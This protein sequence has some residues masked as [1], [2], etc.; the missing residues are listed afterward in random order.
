MKQASSRWIALGVLTCGLATVSW[1]DLNQVVTL[2][3][4]SALNM[5]TGATSSSGGD[6]LWTG[7]AITP[8]GNATAAS[9]GDVPYNILT[10]AVITNLPGFSKAEISGRDLAVNQV[11]VVHTNANRYAKALVQSNSG[12]VIRLQFTTYGAPAGTSGGPVITAIQNNSSR[13]RVGLPNYGIAPSS[14]FVVTGNALSDA[15]Q[16][17]LQSSQPP[18]LPI[19]LNGTSITVVVNGVTTRPPLYYTSPGQ[20]AAVMPANTPVGSGTLTVTHNGL[21]SAPAT[22]QVVPAALGI[23]TYDVNT[24][25]ATD[26]ATGALLTYTNSGSP[27]QTI[28]LWTTGLGANPA[29]SD[30]TFTTTP[31]S[32][33]TS[34]QIFIGG[35]PAT[36]LYQGA[37]G[38]PAVNQINLTIPQAVSTGC[39]VPL[40]AI[41]GNV[42]SNVVTL[43]IAT[44]GGAC[45]D[46]VSGLNGSQISPAGGT[47]T[48]R[49]GLVSLIQTTTPNLRAGPTVSQSATAAFIRYTG[50]SYTPQNSVSP[51][52]CILPNAVPV[53][54]LTGLDPGSISLTGPSGVSTTLGTPGGIRGTFFSNLPANTLSSG[55]TFTFRGTGGADVGA[56]T[57]TITLANPL[58]NWTNQSAAAS[59]DR[60]QGLR[61]T[62]TG[63]NPGSFVSISGAAIAGGLPVG[64][65][66]LAPAE[67]GQFTVPSYILQSLP[68]G[69]GS[70]LVQNIVYAP[71]TAS[72]LDIALGVATIAQ[73]ADSTYG[74]PGLSR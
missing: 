37:S 60:S 2:Q 17:E 23:N 54:G 31:H 66:C 52:G 44:G 36:I 65:L 62:W 63:G 40:A 47:A 11:I 7:S 70:P 68:A 28:V 67:A 26:G 39:W 34:L 22:L 19:T 32:V 24:G 49:T 12:G 71:L 14:L 6:L 21:N 16:P 4:N 43:P 64:Y 58:L 18:G 33:N 35:V 5:E 41:A 29:D 3:A 8:Q 27:G 25:V 38:Y 13:I 51:G 9:A 59:I 45:S 42:V 74:S 1:A 72:G 57:S 10:L 48:F 53:P 73:Q 56:F 50:L 46:T 30:T 61:V 15:G 20:V 55:G 69:N